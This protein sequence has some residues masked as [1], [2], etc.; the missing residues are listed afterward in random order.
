MAV[1]TYDNDEFKSIDCIPEYA[2]YPTIYVAKT[3]HVDETGR[4]YQ[5]INTAWGHEKITHPIAGHEVGSGYLQVPLPRR[6]GKRVFA[7]IHRLVLATWGH[8]PKNYQ[9]L[10]INHR[11]ENPYNN[12]LANLEWVTPRENN[13]YG[14][15]NQ[16]VANSSVKHA[17]SAQMVAINIQT[18]QEFHFA[19]GRECA[20]RLG[21][22]QS[23][24]CK[25]LWGQRYQHRGYVFCWEEEYSPAKVDELIAAT[26]RRKTKN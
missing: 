23:S 1:I 24:V 26:T 17:T 6:N 4:S 16:R 18:K 14:T 13:N 20:R 15:H 11:D 12:R 8:V 5:V 21:L 25:C 2:D 7:L 9:T 19:I 3:P 22:T 10:Q